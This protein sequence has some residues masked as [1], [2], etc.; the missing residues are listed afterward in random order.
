MNPDINDERLEAIKKTGDASEDEVRVMASTI[1]WARNARASLRAK[2]DVIAQ[3]IRVTGERLLHAMLEAWRE[4]ATPATRRDPLDIKIDIVCKTCR[5]P[6][7]KGFDCKGPF[8]RAHSWQHDVALA[9]A[10]CATCGVTR[11]DEEIRMS[12][13]SCAGSRESRLKREAAFAEMHRTYP[14]YVENC[15]AAAAHGSSLCPHHRDE[16]VRLK[17]G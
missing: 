13:S 10:T 9:S 15:K 16:A 2:D 11:T 12:I 5:D 4:R 3:E 6:A 17:L 14:C 8:E 7:C 1:L